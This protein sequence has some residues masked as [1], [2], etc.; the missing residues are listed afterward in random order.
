[1]KQSIEKCLAEYSDKELV[2]F[3]ANLAAIIIC[4]DEDFN[5]LPLASNVQLAIMGRK[6]PICEKYLV[7]LEET[8]NPPV[9]YKFR[10]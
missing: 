1:M 8:L 10:K 2:E 7:K 5:L 3:H 6:T 9:E 4:C